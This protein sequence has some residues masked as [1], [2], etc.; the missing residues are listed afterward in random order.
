MSVWLE[1]ARS[2]PSG[3]VATP[4]YLAT[5]AGLAMLASGGNAIDAALAA[6][7]VLAVVTPYMCGVGGDLL[8][9]VWD[10]D[11]HAYRGVGRAPAGATLGA[12]REESGSEAMPTFGPHACTVPGAVDG[13][14]T[15]LDRWGTRSFGDVSAAARRYAIDGFPLTR[16]GAWFFARNAQ[17][18]EHFGLHDFTDAYG[19]PTAGAWVRQPELARTL[20]VLADDG[21]DAYY[22]G[23]IGAAIA[24]RL[25]QA[26]GFLTSE[27]LAAHAGAWVEPLRT[28]VRGAEILEMPP[29]TQG[30]AALE[31]LRITDRL[32]LGADGPDRQHLLIESMKMALADRDEYLGDPAAMTVDCDALLADEWIGDRRARLDPAR[33]QHF[34]PRRTPSGGTIY[35][36]AADRDGL[37]VSLIQSNFFGAG[38]GLR[39]GEWGINL[40]NRGSAF[41]F[42]A[43]HPNVFGPSKMPLHTL[44]PGLALR[45]GRPWLVFGSEGGHGQA[46]THLQIL[47]RML[48]DGD[49]PQAAISA[50]RF[51]IDPDTAR[52]AIEDHFDPAWIEE[53]RRRGHDLDVVPGHRHGPGI[54]H[55]IE[56]LVSGYR[57]GSDPRAEGGTAGL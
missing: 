28:S 50:P 57:A 7:L 44:I 20:Q 33:A 2:Y 37:L 27:D 35:L 4:H 25:Q 9:I 55:A 42:D 13:W 11:V 6:N 47:T 29:P 48:V 16:R 22:R 19:A 12:V 8:A 41:N 39:V 5:S 40:H 34:S 43:G 17:T 45:D 30:I 38:C 10:G 18:F 51:T 56:C 52:V 14:F 53:L 1:Q 36:N 46:Q 31:A 26:G 49:D 3:V 54:A 24:Q 21:P 15:L 32:D 23:P